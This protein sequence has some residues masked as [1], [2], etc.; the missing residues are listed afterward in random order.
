MK[1]GSETRCCIELDLSL[2]V[3]MGFDGIVAGFWQR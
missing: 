1:T 2:V 3:E